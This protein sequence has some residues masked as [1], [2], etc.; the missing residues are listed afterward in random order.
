MPTPDRPD[1]QPIGD[2]AARKRGSVINAAMGSELLGIL[3][4]DKRRFDIAAKLDSS[5]MATPQAVGR[6]TTQQSLSS[7]AGAC[8]SLDDFKEGHR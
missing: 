4:E 2:G 5:A 1:S 3:Y 7:L 8:K 6:L